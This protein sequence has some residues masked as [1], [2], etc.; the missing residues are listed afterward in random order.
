[1]AARGARA[2]AERLGTERGDLPER[3]R[4]LP[5][6]RVRPGRRPRCLRREAARGPRRGLITQ[7]R[8]LTARPSGRAVCDDARMDV[9]T[10]A[11]LVFA[12]AAIGVI[13]F[14]L[15]LAFGAPWGRYAMGGAF[16]GR[17]PPGMRVAA[18]VQAGLIALLAV[19][20]LSAAGLVVPELAA[21]VSLARLGR[22]RRLGPCG[23][24]ER[25]QPERGRTPDLGPGRHRSLRIEPDRRGRYLSEREPRQ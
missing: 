11:A 7:A 24:P 8:V 19:V 20:V 10:I 9:T 2:V 1:M 25:N 17:M 6:W 16:P 5:R 12:V 14:Q 22:R 18:V 15:A 21:R 13:A 23:R 3:P 4:R